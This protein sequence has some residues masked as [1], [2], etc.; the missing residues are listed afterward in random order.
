MSW[1]LGEIGGEDA[2]RLWQVSLRVSL[3]IHGNAPC[4]SSVGSAESC[5]FISATDGDEASSWPDSGS[6]SRGHWSGVGGDAISLTSES[7][8]IDCEF[9]TATGSARSLNSIGVQSSP[10]NSPEGRENE[11]VGVGIVHRLIAVTASPGLGN[12]GMVNMLALLS[13]RLRSDVNEAKD[14]VL[15][16]LSWSIRKQF[17]ESVGEL[18]ISDA[19]RIVGLSLISGANVGEL[20]GRGKA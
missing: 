15:S 3:L 19:R 17:R 16:L 1:I 8:G 4:S 5:C 18:G 13:T 12:V 10:S 6:T 7:S 20:G 14:T 2:W 9:E 11:N